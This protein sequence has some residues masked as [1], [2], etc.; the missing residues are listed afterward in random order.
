MFKILKQEF[1]FLAIMI[2]LMEI[3]RAVLIHYQPETALFDRGSL[4]ESFLVSMWEITW[5]SAASWILLW[6]IFPKSYRSL[7]GF[8]NNFGSLPTFERENFGK[9]IWLIIFLSLVFLV[10]MRGQT[11]EDLT[12]HRLVDTLTAQLDVR[13]ATGHND[14]FEVERYLHFVGQTKGASW[15]AAFTSYNYAA[16]GIVRPV[17][18]VSAWAPAFSNSKYVISSQALLK[19]R[20]AQ[21]VKPGDCFT[22]YYPALGRVGHVGFIVDQTPTS[23]ITI[24]GN[25]GLAGSREGSGVHKLKR[26]KDKIYTCSNLITPYLKSHETEKAFISGRACLPA[27]VVYLQGEATDN[28]KRRAAYRQQLHKKGQYLVHGLPAESYRGTYQTGWDSTGGFERTGTNGYTQSIL[29]EIRSYCIHQ[30]WETERTVCLQRPRT[31]GS[32]SA[33]IDTGLQKSKSVQAARKNF[34]KDGRGPVYT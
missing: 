10:G 15:C 6:I 20:K 17:N 4:L 21:K 31:K 26:P 1:F 7:K 25:T 18:P 3:F 9:K 27:H 19:A 29:A 11:R 14:G 34:R 24:E 33:P 32:G 16:V 2:V 30:R 28:R 5:I 23:F 12:R 22:L 13:E 8:Y